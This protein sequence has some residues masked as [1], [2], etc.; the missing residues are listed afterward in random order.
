MH[1]M[2]EEEELVLDDKDPMKA[3]LRK[4]LMKKQYIDTESKRDVIADLENLEK[5]SIRN[6]KVPSPII[7][8]SPSKINKNPS[9]SVSIKSKI[10]RSECG[11]KSDIMKSTQHQWNFVE[12]DRINKEIA[13]ERRSKPNLESIRKKTKQTMNNTAM[14]FNSS[15]FDQNHAVP[16]DHFLEQRDDAVDLESRDD[17]DFDRQ[18]SRVPTIVTTNEDLQ[19][20]TSD[21][22][23]LMKSP[24]KAT[25]S[26]MRD[27]FAR[28]SSFD[29]R[30]ASH[31][32]A[33]DCYQSFM[34][35]QNQEHY[36]TKGLG[37]IPG[38]RGDK[39][40]NNAS[41]LKSQIS[42]NFQH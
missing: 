15:L 16:D 7:K 18:R 12:K 23:A 26:K 10:D 14:N 22:T 4:Q 33:E 41:P 28:E 6:L 31:L 8:K 39:S 35:K 21:L 9:A 36:E 24:H 34:R 11:D 38:M 42:N 32:E 2:N 5:N 17:D 30:S 25:N 37:F 29:A 3:K 1:L 27:T 40:S 13:E 20:K 19:N